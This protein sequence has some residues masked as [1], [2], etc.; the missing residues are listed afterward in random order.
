M[1]KHIKC[2]VWSFVLL[3]VFPLGLRAQEFVYT[4]NDLRTTNSITAFS[5]PS[6]GDLSEIAG[7]PFL[8]GGVGTGGGL[9]SAN[10]ITVV[11][12]FLYASNSAYD[13]STNSDSVSAFT[14]DPN[15]GM[16]TSVAPPYAT[17][18]FSTMSYPGV[19]LAATPTGNFLY[20]G[21]TDGNITIFSINSSTGALSTVGSAAAGG[22]MSS[23]KVTP[24]GRYL[25]VAL[26]P[27]NKVAMFTINSGGTLAPVSGS[28]FTASTTGNGYIT[29]IDINCASTLLF[30]GRSGS[31]IDV[32][33]I[34][35]DGT[36]SELSTSPF[37]TSVPSNQV[38]ALSTDDW[39]LYSSNQGSNTVT[40]F[41]VG[42]DG[43]L[44]VPGTPVGAG[45]NAL[46]P[47]G[48]AVSK[49]GNFLYAADVADT[50]GTGGVGG[51]SSFSLGG[52]SP[53]SF[54]FLTSTGQ[55]SGLRSLAAYPAKACASSSTSSGLT[56]SL[57]IFA[58]PPPGFSL[59]AT[60]T[61]DSSLVVD[62]LTQP[63]TIT[64]GSFT[65]NLPAGSFKTFQ[66]GANAATYLFQGVV[67]STTLK[68]QI[69]PLGQNQF[70]ISAY[71]KQIDLSSLD[72]QSVPV[73]V[74]IGGNSAS[75]IDPPIQASSARGNWRKY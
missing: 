59:D 61:L 74:G 1:L 35:S 29:G 66:S 33:N 13:M 39:T 45:S 65:L 19:S 7:S 26:Y 8:T 48:L 75:A 20:A 56:E 62:P 38:V 49:D 57:Q 52:S 72:K 44:T 28:P 46:Y 3:A 14:I 30:A 9:Y 40:A 53:L 37:S 71:D 27:L 67:N 25:A 64:V 16:L 73:T 36:L 12:N 42:S 70:Q 10:R 54:D 32:F 63:V 31:N 15:T 69:T 22:A 47:G 17:Q 24:N 60:L 41:A 21:T 5:V 18:G 50:A 6:N 11:G 51:V 68:V 43:S 58:G 55:T 4:N 23:M 2:F 34:G